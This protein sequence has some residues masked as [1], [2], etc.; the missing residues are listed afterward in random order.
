MV[1]N[2]RLDHQ[3]SESEDDNRPSNKKDPATRGLLPRKDNFRKCKS[4][5]SKN[6]PCKDIRGKGNPIID[7]STSVLSVEEIPATSTQEHIHN[8]NDKLINLMAL[9]F[10]PTR[11]YAR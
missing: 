9:I 8:I 4:K 3:I 7:N 10:G 1:S 11:T 2:I 5:K 6:L